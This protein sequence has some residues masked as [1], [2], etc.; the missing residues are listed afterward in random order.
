MKNI[1]ILQKIVLKNRLFNHR[2]T[3]F[4]LVEVMVS[5]LILL[6]ALGGIVPLFLTSKLQVINNEIETGGIAVSQ[7]LIDELRQ[8]PISSLPLN[9]TFTTLPGGED[10]STITYLGKNYS[11]RIIYCQ[12]NDPI[13]NAETRKIK[14]EVSFNDRLVHEVETVYTNISGDDA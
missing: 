14:I 3:G 6:A 10:I 5:L 1:S 8:A 12:N 7:T 2:E 4:T 11:P 9:N 13:C